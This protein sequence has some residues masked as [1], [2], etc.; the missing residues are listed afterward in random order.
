MDQSNF[1][2]RTNKVMIYHEYRLT[3]SFPVSL[4]WLAAKGNILNLKIATP[5]QS[6][7]NVSPNSAY[8]KFIQIF[9]IIYTGSNADFVST[10]KLA[11]HLQLIELIFSPRRILMDISFWLAC[12]IIIVEFEQLMAILISFM[13][14]TLSRPLASVYLTGNFHHLTIQFSFMIKSS[15]ES[16]GGFSTTLAFLWSLH[17]LLRLNNVRL[18]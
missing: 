1:P 3:V 15:R 17:E 4:I 16:C 18:G 12:S 6:A 8:F 11:I 13:T 14:Q 5:S 2:R 10:S 7:C 9:S